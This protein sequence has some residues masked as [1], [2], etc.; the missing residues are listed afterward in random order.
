M[1]TRSWQRARPPFARARPFRTRETERNTGTAAGSNGVN[2]GVDASNSGARC[3]G[4]TSFQCNSPLIHHSL[5][6]FEIRIVPGLSLLLLFL[7]LRN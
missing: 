7:Q 3:K 1:F 5:K 2:A 4:A 6:P